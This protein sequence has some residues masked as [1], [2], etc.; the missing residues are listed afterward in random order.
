MSHEIV[1]HKV[2]GLNEA[3]RILTLDDPGPGGACHLYEIGWGSGP[4]DMGDYNPTVIK[5]QKGG[6]QE[7]GGV[8]GISN[9]ALLAIVEDRLAHFQA[10][11]YPC[12]EN[13]L[14]LQKVREAMMWLQKR[15]LDRMRRGVEGV[16]VK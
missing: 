5:F 1:S 13:S 8:N 4:D 6:I 3:L 12:E 7:V 15:T 16:S 14:A 9:E 11:P 2:N 10:G